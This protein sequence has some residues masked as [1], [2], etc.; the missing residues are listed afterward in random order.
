MT[1]ISLQGQLTLDQLADLEDDKTMIRIQ[2]NKINRKCRAKGTQQ[3]Y[4]NQKETAMKLVDKYLQ[5][6]DIHLYTL[7]AL[8][9]CGK[10]GTLLFFIKTI[11]EHNNPQKVLSYKNIFVITGLSSKGWVSQMKDRTPTLLLK[12]V[13][14][15]GQLDKFKQKVSN[16]KDILIVIDEVDYAGLEDCQ[17]HKIFNDLHFNDIEYL[18]KNNI[19]ILQVSATPDGILVDSENENLWKDY[20]FKTTMVTPPQYNSVFKLLNKGYVSQ[21]YDLRLN[22]HKE[23]LLN[24]IEN[25][26]EEPRYHIVRQHNANFNMDMFKE[27]ITNKNM[28]W[29]EYYQD[30]DFKINELL[31]KQPQENTIIFIK[32]KLRCSITLEKQYIGVLFERC[33]VKPNDSSIIQ[34]LLG[35][36]TGYYDLE[37][38]NIH[39][40]TN[41]DT[42][43]RY[44]AIYNNGFD[45]SQAKWVSNT[46]K[47]SRNQDIVFD[48]VRPEIK[49]EKPYTAEIF[50]TV[51]TQI[52]DG[53][54]IKDFAKRLSILKANKHKEL[55]DSD[56]KPRFNKKVT[57]PKETNG[58]I[59]CKTLLAKD[60]LSTEALS[61]K[62]ETNAA[63][64][65][66]NLKKDFEK[67]KMKTNDVHFRLYYSYNNLD[68]KNSLVATFK[69]VKVTKN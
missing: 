42:I 58:Y 54:S 59:L 4:G 40:F 49:E 61:I 66:L 16:K 65:N 63:D 13:F 8:T 64:S 48:G 38:S 25:K 62:F 37:N 1:A 51:S 50:D 10:T 2:F 43:N 29:I 12:N 6:N 45:Y 67:G 47:G 27:L 41:I 69:Y 39:I 52:N 33:V 44:E 57:E 46:I 23:E 26:Y 5:N 11:I 35:R 3:F 30:D 17:I 20:H 7:S 18:Q 55:K 19:H 36:A 31:V 32:E 28:K 34:G 24:F 60:P 68:N 56:Y 53:E 14:H 9:Q 22:I 21:Y 15:G